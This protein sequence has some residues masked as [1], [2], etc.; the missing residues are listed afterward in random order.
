MNVLLVDNGIDYGRNFIAFFRRHGFTVTQIKTAFD[1]QTEINKNPRGYDLIII[2]GRPEGMSASALMSEIK[3]VNDDIP[4]IIISDN[5][6]I[7]EQLTRGHNS[8]DFAANKTLDDEA[9]LELMTKMRE[10][11]RAYR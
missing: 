8:A 11:I 10:L 4:I 9:A 6:A 3:D 5:M 1:A 2:E 7:L